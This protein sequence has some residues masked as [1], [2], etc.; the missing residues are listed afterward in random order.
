M[1]PFGNILTPFAEPAWYSTLS[2]PYYT[3]K[4][5][6][7][8]AAARAYHDKL[9]AAAEDWEATG[10]VPRKAMEAHARAGWTAASIWPTPS[11]ELLKKAGVQLPAGLAPSE[12]DIWC[13]F[14][15]VD[16]GARTGFLGAS[17]GLTGG[18]S[19]GAPPLVVYGTPEQQGRLLVPILNG[20]KRICLGITEP[21]GGSDVSAIRTTATRTEEGYR[22]SG[23]KK[24]ITNGMTADYMMTAVRTG[25][26]GAAGL[27]LL[28]VPLD[29]PGVERRKILNTGV[30]ASGSAYITMEDVLVPF[31]NLIGKEGQGFK[32]VM[33][34]F[35]H[36]RLV[37]S[38]QSN[39]MARVCLED[40]YEYAS[41]R[42]T[43]GKRL[44]DQPVI[45]AKLSDMAQ[46]IER[47]HAWLE[48]LAYH[49]TQVSKAEADRDLAGLAALLKVSCTRGLE[50][51]NREALQILGGIGYQRGGRGGRVEQIS[52]DLRV[53]AIGGGSEEIMSD[54]G[55]RM[56]EQL[57]GLRSKSKL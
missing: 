33:T 36:E 13:D 37:L 50:K 48:Q 27:S 32:M 24:W 38:I 41:T 30:A 16:E 17:W 15:S 39:R 22:V 3:D 31:D 28:V 43:F 18:N 7:V 10:D 35:L 44:L 2:S 26:A 21:S 20:G 19:I 29:A 49:T 8:R 53:M 23:E 5:R 9:A 14:I 47:N 34:N 52:R 25:G 4:H 51:C 46:I 6:R 40:A 55:L 12:W 54:L 57:A 1:Q 11:A 56:A 45:R 42:K